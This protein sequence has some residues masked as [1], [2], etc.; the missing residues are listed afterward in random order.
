MTYPKLP[1]RLWFLIT[2]RLHFHLYRLKSPFKIFRTHNNTV[3][4][5]LRCPSGYF[6]CC[7]WKGALKSYY[8]FI[9]PIVK[10]LVVLQECKATLTWTS[11]LMSSIKSA[12]AG[13]STFNRWVNLFSKSFASYN[14]N[15]NKYKL[16][17]LIKWI[18]SLDVS[19]Y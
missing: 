14:W 8:T 9:T 5:E 19:S 3:S 15:I 12:E 4:K 16:P 1:K 11:S 18:W 13:S 6:K 2:F 10:D 17:K 7:Q